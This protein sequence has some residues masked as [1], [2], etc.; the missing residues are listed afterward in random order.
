MRGISNAERP[1]VYNCG[2]HLAKG[3][4]NALRQINKIK[5]NIHFSLPMASR[6]QNN[7]GKYK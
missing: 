2:I 1:V 3:M 5:K 4:L 6:R 7:E